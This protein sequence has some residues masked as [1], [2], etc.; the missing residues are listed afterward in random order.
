MKGMKE[1][2]TEELHY[3]EKIDFP[4]VDDPAAVGKWAVLD[5]RRS[6]D[7]FYAGKKPDTE[8]YGEQIREIYPL[9]GGEQ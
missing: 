6:R 5:R 9:P 3:N 8:I 1:M 2:T 4:F 7:D